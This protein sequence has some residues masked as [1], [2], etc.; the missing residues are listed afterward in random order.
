MNII[1]IG[2]ESLDIEIDNEIYRL[3]GENESNGFIAWV[4][5]TTLLAKNQI[6]MSFDERKK[7][8]HNMVNSTPTQFTALLNDNSISIRTN[9]IELDEANKHKIMEIICKAWTEN[10]KITFLDDNH[11]IVGCTNSE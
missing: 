8:S 1:D 9:L 7:L 6:Q 11:N 10:F 5:Q 3:S 4:S 2:K